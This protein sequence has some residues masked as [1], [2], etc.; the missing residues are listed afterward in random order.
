V[1]TDSKTSCKEI[2]KGYVGD[3]IAWVESED[4]CDAE[5]NLLFHFSPTNAVPIEVIVQI[6]V[7]GTM[8]QSTSQGLTSNLFLVLLSF[9]SSLYLTYLL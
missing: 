6:S 9:S 1:D 3:F 2:V 8:L 5:A 7:Y 4:D